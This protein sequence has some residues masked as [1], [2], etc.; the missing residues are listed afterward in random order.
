M[1]VLV[2]G[3][4]G[5]IGSVLCSM[6]SE[7]GHKVFAC[8]NN[9]DAPDPPNVVRR[10]RSSFED[11]FIIHLVR[12]YDIDLIVHLAATSTVG[13]DSTDPLLY[14]SNNTAK[15]TI[16]LEKLKNAYWKGH[17]VF[18]ST[19]A[20]Y[21][22]CRVPLKEHFNIE[23]S[24]VYGF[25]KRLCEQ[26]VNHAN[27]YDIKTTTF[28]FFNVAGSYNGFGEEEGDTHLLSRI[29]HSVANNEQ[30][31]VYG[32]DYPTRDGTC[33]RDYV[34]VGDVCAAI[35]WALE[36]EKEGTYNLGSEHGTTVTEMIE[37][38]TM[39]TGRA[40]DYTVG[41]RRSG[42]VPSLIA[43][44]SLFCRMSGF[45]YKYSIRD[46]INSSWEQY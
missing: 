25:S 40:V 26:I 1:K 20:V 30:L 45:Q 38:F 14:L 7:Q 5:Y 17:F 16:F 42:D 11:D 4:C 28:R 46:I 22:S 41:P 9:L 35:I 33:I 15:T 13:P 34:H 24:S 27:C 3:A 29:C 39:H 18:A 23:P 6:L 2:T 32:D 44:P 8:D 36:E 21:E 12:V 43:D 19:A 10:L 37:Q 31:V